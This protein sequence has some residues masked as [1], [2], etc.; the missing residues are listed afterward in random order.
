MVEVLEGAVNEPIVEETKQPIILC[1]QPNEFKVA[2]HLE[3]MGLS[4]V[5]FMHEDLE[6]PFVKSIIKQAVNNDIKVV[7]IIDDSQQMD[8]EDVES[9]PLFDLEIVETAEGVELLENAR[10]N[11]VQLYLKLITYINRKD[12]ATFIPRMQYNMWQEGP[13]AG[14]VRAVQNLPDT[15]S[16]KEILMNH[17]NKLALIPFYLKN[18]TIND[19]SVTTEYIYVV[20]GENFNEKLESFFLGAWA[21]F[22]IHYLR[23]FDETDKLLLTLIQFGN[24][25]ININLDSSAREIIETTVKYLA[26]L[27]HPMLEN[28]FIQQNH[29]LFIQSP[30]L[31]PNVYPSI[32]HMLYGM[33][34]SRDFNVSDLVDGLGGLDP[35]EALYFSSV[36]NGDGS[37]YARKLKLSVD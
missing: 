14:Y 11:W 25:L 28:L 8:L 1:Y 23:E 16:D 36:I 33:Q 26:E 35:D 4:R 3:N 12:R 6:H 13:L 21:I 2:W 20:S 9:I 30:L 10:R 29:A 18:E 34:R 7:R 22:N 17:F 5:G 19:E 27:T 15:N 32:S 24:E 37:I 31:F